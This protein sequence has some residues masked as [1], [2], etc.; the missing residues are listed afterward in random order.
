MGIKKDIFEEI[1]DVL[2]ST[3]IKW[4][5]EHSGVSMGCL[6]AWLDGTTQLPRLDTI[7]KVADCLGFDLEL[8]RKATLRQVA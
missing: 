5:C 7:T 8:V 1:K 2:Y 4:V 3:E 6:Y